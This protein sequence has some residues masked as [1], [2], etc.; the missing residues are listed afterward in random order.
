MKIKLTVTDTKKPMK[1]QT[2]QGNLTSFDSDPATDYSHV[3]FGFENAMPVAVIF[4]MPDMP[5]ILQLKKDF[6]KGKIGGTYK[7]NTSE[8]TIVEVK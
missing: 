4:S 6:L 7:I 2:R 5:V 1:F 3:T 8:I